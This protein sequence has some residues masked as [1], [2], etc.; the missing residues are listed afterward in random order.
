MTMRAWTFDDFIPGQPIGE[1]ILSLDDQYVTDWLAIYTHEPDPRPFIPAGMAMLIVMRG[2]A[3]AVDPRPP[4][5]VHAGQRLSIESVPRVGDTLTIGI[6][7][8][9]KTIKRDRRWVTFR[10]DVTDHHNKL[11]YRGDITSI[12]AL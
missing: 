11:C 5:N 1:G 9:D 2:F 3:Q 12:W 4:G 10:V 7:C 8:E 6:G